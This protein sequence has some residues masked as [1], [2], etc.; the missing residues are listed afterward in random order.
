MKITQS[1][2]SN[3]H[4]F[5]EKPICN[6]LREL[7]K[8]VK[9]WNKKQNKIKFRSNLILRSSPLFLWLKKKIQEGYFGKVYSIDAEYLYGRIEKFVSGWRGLS[10]DYSPM[11]GGGIHMIDLACWLMD[12]FPSEVTS[13][14]S[15]YATKNYKLKSNDYM[16][17]TLKFKNGLVLRAVSN[18]ACILKHQHVL[19]IYGTKRTFVYDDLGARVYSTKSTKKYKKINLKNLPDNK[20]N[21]LKEFIK[22]IKDNKNDIKNSIFDLKIMN[23]LCYCKIAD[24]TS[25]KQNIKYI[26]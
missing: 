7:K 15:N 24:K 13:I 10:K 9:I 23:I 5:T 11:S 22:N 21:I 2:K 26:L 3:K 1:I 16:S 17:S 18:L 6:N 25:K 12:D 14:S 19:K 4:V 8:I 20:T